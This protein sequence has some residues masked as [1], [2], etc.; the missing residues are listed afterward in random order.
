MKNRVSNPE[1]LKR[2]AKRIAKHDAPTSTPPLDLSFENHFN[3]CLIR[4]MTR[5]G[6]QWL[7]ENVGDDDTIYFGN[8]VVCEPRYVGAIIDGAKQVGMVVG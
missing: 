8:A 6:Q 5:A 4:P 2:I 1:Y 7:E 3:I